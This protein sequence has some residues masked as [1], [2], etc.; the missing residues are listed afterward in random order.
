LAA[1]DLNGDEIPDLIV[2]NLGHEDVPGSQTLDVFF[3]R[4]DGQFTLMQSIAADTDDMPYGMAVADLRGTGACDVIVPNKCSKTVAVFLCRG[5]GTFE[6]PQRF[7]ADDTWSASAADLDGDEK[8]DLAVANFDTESI[9]FLAGNGDGTFRDAEKMPASAGMKPRNV[10]FGDFDRDGRLDLAVPSDTEDGRVAVFINKS[11]PGRISFIL[12]GIIRV[13][14]FTGAVVVHDLD[15]DGF[16]DIVA[17]SLDS[18][19]ISVLHG[20]GDGS[21]APATHFGTGEIWPFE[22]VLTD[23]DGDGNPDLSIAGVK[24]ITSSVLLGDGRGGFS[25]PYHFQIDGPSRWLTAG[26]FNLDGGVDVAIGNYTITGRF[27]AEPHQF[28]RTVSLFLN[29]TGQPSSRP[30]AFR[31]NCGGSAHTDSHGVAFQADSNFEGGKVITTA[32]PIDGTGDQTIY[33]SAREGD[34]TYTADVRAGRAY[35]VKLHFAEIGKKSKKRIFNVSIN[36]QPALNRF[37]LRSRVPRLTA[38]T[39]VLRE[40]WPDREGRIRLA[41]SGVKRKAICSGISVF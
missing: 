27:D 24:G 40:V 5:D 26:D 36:G 21:F 34:F 30:A 1:D 12:T 4:G 6:A 31:A 17:S 41:F 16:L 7:A 15:G 13:G 8:I 14:V 33:Q 29:R 23:L 19:R 20:K 9:T 37:D 18:N 11:M 32:N 39:V 2:A 35:T 10:R 38:T 28:F 22:M 3:G 25:S